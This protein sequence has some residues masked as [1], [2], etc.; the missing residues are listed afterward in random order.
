MSMD[1]HKIT[2][3]HRDFWND[4][5]SDMLITNKNLSR[6]DSKIITERSFVFSHFFRGNTAKELVGYQRLL[7][8]NDYGYVML[9]EIPDPYRAN[10]IY[11]SID[12]FRLHHCIKKVL[13]HKKCALGP[14]LNKRIILLISEDT[15]LS[16][17]I[18]R[19]ESLRIFHE[20]AEAIEKEFQ[21]KI[22]AGIG[23]IHNL[24][25]INSSLTDA[26]FCLS[27][28]SNDSYIYY[29]DCKNNNN[30]SNLDYITTINHLL[31][32]VRLRKTDAFDYFVILMDFI[33][34]F[35]DRI[36]RS[37]ILELLV[38]THHTANLD[39]QS[40]EKT[41]DSTAVVAEMIHLKEDRLIEYGCQIFMYITSTTKHQNSIDYSNHIVK[42]TK[43]YLE[44]HYA[45]DI[46]LEDMAAY[47]N[48]SPPYFSKLIKK[49]TGFNFIDWLSMLRVK[50]AKELLT[51]SNYTVKEVCFM[52]GYKDPN[53]FSRIFKKRI[54]ITPSEFVKANSLLNNKS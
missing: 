37:K 51:N 48:I 41:F 50:K 24:L 30:D 43:E 17:D 52:V 26:R 53:Y 3:E 46:S 40:D 4:L 31:D 42:A 33:R 20:L 22:F 18:H 9:L 8:L 25:S 39:H 14:L 44:T 27:S 2:L 1:N 6:E 28:N 13:Q 16:E 34:P 49:N 11:L 15:V 54:G 21:V 23:S 19:D 47:V 7:G 38:L 36:K 5:Q 29:L 12:E 10:D 32:S 45:E 35:N